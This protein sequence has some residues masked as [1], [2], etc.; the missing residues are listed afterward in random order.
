MGVRRKVIVVGAVVVGLGIGGV[1]SASA[2]TVTLV[3]PNGKQVVA[4]DAAVPGA[5][6]ALTEVTVNVG[7]DHPLEFVLGF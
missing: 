6:T 5:V 7:A 1:G 4:P 2:L 3:T